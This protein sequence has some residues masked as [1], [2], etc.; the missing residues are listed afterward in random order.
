MKPPQRQ[1]SQVML[2]SRPAETIGALVASRFRIIGFHGAGASSQVLAANDLAQHV[3]VM[4]KVLLRNDDINRRRLYRERDVARR[5]SMSASA[6]SFCRLEDVF[7]D[8]FPVWGER[9]FL[10]LE[11]IVGDTLGDVMNAGVNDPATI[12]AMMRALCTA[13]DHAHRVGVVHGD[14]KPKNIVLRDGDVAQPVLLDFGSAVLDDRDDLQQRSR[15][16]SVRFAAP[17]LFS[18]TLPSVQSDCFALAV[19]AFGL[20]HQ[21]YPFEAPNSI[22]LVNNIGELRYTAKTTALQ[23]VF[24]QAFAPRPTRFVS[25][26]AFADALSDALC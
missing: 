8:V 23:G 25:A 17:E 15:T 9:P 2:T 22:D 7:I 6:R 12:D 19:I 26:P 21:T 1:S 11:P 3:P 14:L 10:A 4:L 20:L 13:V 16:G 5:L 18:G 24:D